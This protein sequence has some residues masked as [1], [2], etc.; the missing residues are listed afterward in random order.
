MSQTRYLV[1]GSGASGIA[2]AKALV[3]SGASVQVIDVGREAEPDRREVFD[4]LAKSEP[5]SWPPAL[6]ERARSS[7]Q[8][9]TKGVPL[10]SVY[11][12]FFPYA[13]DEPDIPLTMNN[14]EVVPSFARGGL[15][16]A[17][18]ASMLPYEDA[19]ITDWP[20]SR[21]D[22]APHYR[23]VL[24]FVPLA[25]EVDELE[26]R[27]PLFTDS[28]RAMRRTPQMARLLDHLRAHKQRLAEAGIAFGGA[29]LALNM[30]PAAD[31]HCR[32]SG[33][34]MYGCPYDAIYSSAQTLREL[35]GRGE[36]R[37]SSGLHADRIE[38]SGDTVRVHC[39]EVADPHT[40]M[41]FEADRVFVACG[42]VSSTRLVLASTGRDGLGTPFAD[43]LYFLTPMLMTRGA[44]VS[45]A[46]QGITF[47]QAY[48]E[49][50]SN[51]FLRRS[52]HLQV[53][54]YS[55]IMLKAIS[56]RLPAHRRAGAERLLQPV[57]SRL[58]AVQG[59]LHS[60]DS[61][62]LSMHLSSDG[63]RFE[64]HDLHE[65][66]QRVHR[67]VR[68]LARRAPAL[69]L[70]PIPQMTQIG[71]PGKSFHTGGSMPMR[72]RP[73]DA[74]T[75]LLG[76]PAGWRRVHVV[77]TSVLPSIPATTIT[78]TAMANA[79]RIGAAAALLEQ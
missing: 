25:G 75:D 14:A 52:A 33:L 58:V 20:I 76:R 72:N 47:A 77:D 5:E 66:V 28:P 41:V 31:D 26:T 10:K 38:E 51:E 63:V 34:C 22:L 65:G 62:G 12:S 71:L 64:G 69:G 79:H 35:V 23:A 16:N 7:L 36:V 18:G 29:R 42:Y 61:P 24:E 50:A 9:T 27:F 55:D 2:C 68:W 17:W 49:V 30:D 78:L 15:S 4:T 53:Y 37:Y 67:L 60:D 45:T 54:G 32:Y 46:T 44:R 48:L 13:L 39:H 70:V 73:G 8:A 3:A 6:D 57:I 21:A 59:F 1:I 11:G 43:S 40:T 74:D 19:D 56:G